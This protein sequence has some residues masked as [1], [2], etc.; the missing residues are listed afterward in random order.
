MHFQ[1]VR[2]AGRTFAPGFN[3]PAPAA[4]TSAWTSGGPAGGRKVAACVERWRAFQPPDFHGHSD[5]IYPPPPPFSFPSA[6]SLV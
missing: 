3:C 1:R 5:G 2:F 6:I 4:K